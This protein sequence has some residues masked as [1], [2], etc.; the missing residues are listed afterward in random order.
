MKYALKIGAK[1]R[2]QCHESKFPTILNL[3][4][5]HRADQHT[6]SSMDLKYL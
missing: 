3:I 4:L 5:A 2:G 6:L 1:F